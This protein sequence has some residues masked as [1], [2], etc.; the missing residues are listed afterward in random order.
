MSTAQS[1]NQ[2]PAIGSNEYIEIEG[3]SVPAKIDT[4]ADS[5]SIW[6]SD[7]EVSPD[8]ILSFALFEPGYEFYTGKKITRRNFKAAIIRSSNGAEQ[9]RYRTNFKIKLGGYELD[10]SFTLADR[11]K[12]MFPVLIGRK[13][14]TGKFLVNVEKTSVKHS[15]PHTHTKHLNV[16]LNKDPYEFHKKYIR[17]E[18]K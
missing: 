6:V 2:M 9:V 1:K 12:N 7:V 4:G 3:I 16:E 18:K 10:T 5:S 8:G 14:I 11:S 17:K 13:T 15:Q